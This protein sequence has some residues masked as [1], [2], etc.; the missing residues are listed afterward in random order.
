MDVSDLDYSE[1]LDGLL[2][3]LTRYSA[4]H[5]KSIQPFTRRKVLRHFPEY[6]SQFDDEVVRESL[7]EHVGCL[8]VVATYLYPYLDRQVDLGRALIMLAIHDIGELVVGDELTFLKS[9]EQG[10]GELEAAMGMLH[11]YFKPLYREL[12]ELTSNE[13]LFVKSVDKLAPDLFDYLCG[14]EYSIERMV[15]QAG[16]KKEEAIMNI[17]AKK[18]PYMEWSPFLT[19]FHDELFGRFESCA[20]E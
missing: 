11:D 6:I 8:P 18:R 13:A 17:R 1:L 10:P 3:Q 9:A 5:R 12:D 20:D 15:L 7:L 19:R 16:W 14:E 4:I 2:E